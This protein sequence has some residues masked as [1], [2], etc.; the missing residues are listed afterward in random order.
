MNSI[1]ALLTVFFL[2][3]STGA[4]TEGSKPK[5]GGTLR[6]AAQ[7][8]ISN[9]NPFQDTRAMD[10]SVRSLVFEPLLME[11]DYNIRP[12]LAESWEIS[13]DGREY[14]FRLKR[15]VKFHTGKEMSA[16]DVQW[17]FLYTMDPRNRAYSQDVF[18]DVRTVEVLDA[19]TLKV[20]LRLPNA[21]FLSYLTSIQ[22][23][24]VVPKDSLAQG[25]K[26][27]RFPPGSGPFIFEAWRPDLLMVLKW[28]P[29]YWKRGFPISIA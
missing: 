22:G 25:E 20:T 16:H 24:P 29:V 27:G 26:P 8:D 18:K 5:A 21:P 11:E 9:L 2:A 19:A 28:F 4:F 1:G 13:K 17:D 3:F 10:T 12:H 23:L 15:G 6:F 7:R 14:R